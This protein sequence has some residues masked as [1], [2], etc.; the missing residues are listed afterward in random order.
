MYNSI[1][2]FVINVE[3]RKYDLKKKGNEGKG[4]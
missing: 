2:L 3:I 4:I 1:Q